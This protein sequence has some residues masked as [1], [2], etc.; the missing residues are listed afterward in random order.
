MSL[1]PLQQQTAV[2]TLSPSNATATKFRNPPTENSSFAVFLALN[3]EPCFVKE[4]IVLGQS[5]VVQCGSS[6]EDEQ[7]VVAVEL[8]LF[9]QIGSHDLF[10]QS[11]VVRLGRTALDCVRGFI[12]NEIVIALE[13]VKG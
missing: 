13:R 2:V 7:A 12:E 11:R 3:I 4:V 6:W 10:Q 9:I 5:L 1:F 8:S